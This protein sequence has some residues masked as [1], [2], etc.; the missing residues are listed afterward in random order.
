MPVM[1]ITMV[2]VATILMVLG[3]PVIV[4]LGLSS[5]I[6]FWMFSPVPLMTIPTIIFSGVESYLLVSIPFFVL[7]GL[8]ME[9][10]GIAK[11]LISF[12][13]SLVG[14]QRG[15]LGAVNV[16]SSFIFGGI[17]GSSVADTAAIG[18]IMIP[19]MIDDNYDKGYSCAITVI[20]STLAIVV[21]PSILM[22]IL[23]AV[24][25]Q[26]VSWLL[27]G[28]IIPGALMAATMMI[29][30]Y[31]I[32]RRRGYGTLHKFTFSNIWKEFKSGFL[33]LGAPIIILAGILTGFV[34]PTEAGGLACFY[35]L[36]IAFVFYKS[37]KIKTL[38]KSIVNASAISSSVIILIASAALF[39]FILT[40]EGVPQYIASLLLGLTQNRIVILILINLFL[41]MVGMVVDASVATMILVPILFPVAESIGINLIHLGV[42][43]VV[44]FALGLVTPPFG[45]CLFSVCQVGKISMV[46][47]IRSTMPLYLS[48]IL[49][50]ALITVFPQLVLWLPSVLL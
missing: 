17:S 28:G 48:L 31:F 36:F 4:C 34:T 9:S 12:S 2:L 15:G 49:V 35:T 3:F 25:E 41:L 18:S 32:S 39:T 45:L 33:A 24:S 8:L 37:I 29:Q 23:G 11:R 14:W 44:N 40:F 43:F 16:F 13:K 38:L 1:S 42:I 46:D 7:A 47:L 50:L 27:V 21:P 6:A 26:S 22:I 30:N 20:S 19:E 5:L 10:C